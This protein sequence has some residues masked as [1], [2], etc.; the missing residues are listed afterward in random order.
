[1][2]TPKASSA[3]NEYWHFSKKNQLLLAVFTLSLLLGNI[4]LLQQTRTFA[5]SYVN[6]QKQATWFLFQLSKEF[7]ELV[8]EAHRLDENVHNIEEAE[9]QYELT[10][11]RF[12]LLINGR[13]ARL[14]FSRQEIHDY[15]SRLFADFQ[16]LEPLLIKAK[17]EDHQAAALFYR[18]SRSLYMDMVDFVNQ[19]FRLA[20][21][22]HTAQQEKTAHLMQVQYMLL[23]TFVIAVLSLT[24]FFYRE[25]HF[26]RKLALSDPLTKIGNRNALFA[27]LN[28]CTREQTPFSLFLLDLNGFKTIN[29]TMGHLAGDEALKTVAERLDAM[30]IDHFSVYRIGGDEFAVVAE[31]VDELTIHGIRRHIHAVFDQPILVFNQT[32]SLSTSLGCACYPSDHT[33][34]DALINIADKRMYKMKFNQLAD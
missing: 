27:Q 28:T 34:I 1:M 10:W 7:S 16:Q 11:S 6:E 4:M 14:F 2:A 26:H 33:Y 20:S 29:D 30:C 18:R 15:F 9:L 8:G 32:T 22:R 25:S 3:V 21:P 24:F 19:N 31:T 5:E 17:A 13:E 23:G 12:D